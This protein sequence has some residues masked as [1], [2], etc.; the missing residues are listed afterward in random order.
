MSGSVDVRAL[1]LAPSGV[2]H[3]SSSGDSS[4]MARSAVIALVAQG[5]PA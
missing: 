5:R 4:M 3:D 2:G 1:V